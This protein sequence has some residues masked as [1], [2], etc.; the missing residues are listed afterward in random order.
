LHPFDLNW[1]LGIKRMVSENLP[2]GLPIEPEP[3]DFRTFTALMGTAFSV[4][5]VD[6][7]PAPPWQPRM[8]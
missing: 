6:L 2:I 4:L 3:A 8:L 1:E 7:I 5:G